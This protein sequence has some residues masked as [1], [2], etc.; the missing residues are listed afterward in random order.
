M[1][2]QS[3]GGVR[4]CTR[5]AGVFSVFVM[6]W[7]IW[8]TAATAAPL[9]SSGF[10]TD[11]APAGWTLGAFGRQAPDGQWRQ[12]DGRHCLTVNRGYWQ[13]PPIEVAPFGYYRVVFQALAPAGGH[14][15][16]VFFDEAGS[17]LVADNY[18]GID[19][20]PAWQTVTSCVR[21][22]ALARHMRLRFVAADGALSVDDVLVEG[23][24]A[25]A[26]LRWADDLAAGLPPVKF[27][28]PPDRWKLLPRTIARLR[29]GPS[30]R[31]VMLGD[32]IVND[33]SN[34]IFEVL[35]ERAWPRCRIEVV[36]SV[37][38][39]TGCQFYQAEDRVRS[40]VLAFEPDLLIIG[41]ISH[42]Y[43]T[44]AIRSVIRQVRAGSDCEIL[45]MSGAVCP[46]HRCDENFLKHSGLPREKALALISSFPERLMRLA[47]D[48]QV[49][50]LDMRSAW[51]VYIAASPGPLEWFMRDP[52]HANRRGKQVLG[53]IIERYFLPDDVRR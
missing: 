36:T 29:Q 41:G 50:L 25:A 4:T 52:I 6:A 14:F 34:S 12:T 37:R 42:G 39:G 21:A 15:T 16:A 40:Y 5:F 13:S 53:R 30:L 9:L 17:E 3:P 46:Q 22:H 2:L 27:Q 43:D 26:V 48:E 45:L 7:T 28:P 18:D 44:D 47:A 23:C 1:R 49:E 35:L 38:G 8:S 19:A 24:D 33:T 10:E 31:V 51:D 32:S 20:A 11:P